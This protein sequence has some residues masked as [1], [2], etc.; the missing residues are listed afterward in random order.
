MHY[1]TYAL[2]DATGKLLLSGSGS[3]RAVVENTH[4]TP[5]IYLLLLQT[6]GQATTMKLDITE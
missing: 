6:E 3:D 4:L 1:F 5:G 2:Y